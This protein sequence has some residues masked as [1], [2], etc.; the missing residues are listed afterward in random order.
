MRAALSV[1]EPLLASVRQ[2]VAGEEIALDVVCGGQCAVRVE[3]GNERLE[4]DL[5]TLHA[6]GWITCPAAQAVASKLQISNGAMGKILNLL[7]IKIR[8]CDLGCFE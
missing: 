7:Q 6:G 5:T 4:S 3:Q 1:P 8:R 2:L